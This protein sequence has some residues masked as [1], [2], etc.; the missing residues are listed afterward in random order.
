MGGQI[1][2]Y[3]FIKEIES[4]LSE[5]EEDFDGVIGSV[6][7]PKEY[8][9]KKSKKKDAIK[10]VDEEENDGEIVDDRKEDEEEKEP[11]LGGNL[12]DE[13]ILMPSELDIKNGNEIAEF[14]KR[15]NIM[16]ATKSLKDDKVRLKFKEYFKSLSYEE[17][18][19]FY[20]FINGINQVCTLSLGDNE[21]GSKP[22]DYGI[23]INYGEKSSKEEEP[24]QKEE[25]PKQKEREFS[26]SKKKENPSREIVTVI[27][28][29][30]VQ[31]KTEILEFLK[32]IN[33]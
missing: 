28:T 19:T 7:I 2:S 8:K 17:R 6:N 9:A 5:K 13:D 25:E 30:G 14:V 4:F 22:S 27:A 11:D 15:L 32:K 16:R 23:T 24:K 10:G 18:I 21:K 12:E 20:T 29:E 3:N 1:M 33:G 26:F 31:D